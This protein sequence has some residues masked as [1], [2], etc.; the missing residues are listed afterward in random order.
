MSKRTKIMIFS[1][2]GAVIMAICSWITIPGPVP[3]TMQTFAVFALLLIYDGGPA[4]ISISLYL[5]LGAVGV[6]VFAGFTGGVAHLLGPT[7]G[8][9][10][11]FLILAAVYQVLSHI[12]SKKWFK[13][14][15]L[16]IGLVCCYA[17]G[18]WWYVLMYCGGSVD[19]LGTVLMTCVIPFV[20]P[21]AVKMTLAVLL[22]KRVRLQ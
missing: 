20:L 10:V 17:F 14:V 6:P 5:L 22:S 19:E 15:S 16:I 7:G 13:I 11:G 18:T 4:L 21:D 9:L 3:F 12:S 2:L 1:A 8:Y